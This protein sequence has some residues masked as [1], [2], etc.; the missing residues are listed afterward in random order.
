MELLP[1]FMI[2][3]RKLKYKSLFKNGIEEKI[4]E[5]YDKDGNKIKDN[6]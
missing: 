5:F 3:N 2:I 1:I 6:L 4:L